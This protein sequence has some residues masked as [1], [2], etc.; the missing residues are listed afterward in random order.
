[1][2]IKV[3]AQLREQFDAWVQ[4]QRQPA[5]MPE[6]RAAI[7]GEQVFMLNTC[8]SCHTISGTQANGHIGPDLTHIGS[9]ATL[10]AGVLANTPENLRH[11]IQSAQ[12]VKPGVVMPDFGT[13]PE[14]DVRALVAYLG[15]LR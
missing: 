14:D 2:R 11:W 12:E 5:A 4:Q 6:A 15:A 8:V 7:E 9:R 3:V 1:M 10:A 13:L